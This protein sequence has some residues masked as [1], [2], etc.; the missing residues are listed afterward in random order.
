MVP[1]VSIIALCY[2]HARFL[3][4]ALDSILAQTYP[5]L[6]VVLVDDASTDGSADIL[7]RYVAQN[8][9]WQLLL[10]PENQNNCRAFNRGLALSEG[11]FVIDFATDDVLL[12][13]RI[14]RQVAAF[15]QAG[16]RCG[17]VYTDAELLDESGRFV[18][19]YY[20]R[21][22]RGRLHPRPASGLVFADVLERYFISTPTMLMRRATLDALGGY[23]ETLSY[24]DFDFWVRASRDW[25]FQFLDIVSTQKHLHP[26]S[27]SAKSYRR[28][29]PHLAST[30]VVCRKALALCRTPEERAALVVRVRWELR[31]ALRHRSRPEAHALYQLLSELGA[32]GV[33]DWGMFKVLG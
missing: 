1:L 17:M 13:E 14:A 11:D 25:E 19:H 23:D 10:L 16:P 22:A 28:H 26:R 24:E 8:P 27:K 21:D 20:R 7:R 3:E 32:V 15:E 33:V 31:Q 5:H 12:P 9:G 6:E 2:N 30:I 29:D 18:R 4:A